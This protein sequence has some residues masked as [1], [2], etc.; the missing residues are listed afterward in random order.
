M[1]STSST[2]SVR[3]NTKIYLVGHMSHQITGGK[4]PSNGQVLRTL[5]YNTRQVGLS[6]REAATLTLNEVTLFW[7]KARIPT[8]LKKNALVKVEKLHGEWHSLQKG[9]HRKS[10]S[11]EEK[12]LAFKSKLEDLFDIAAADALSLLTNPEDIAFL[13]LQREKGR[14]GCMAGVDL[15]TARIEER[16]NAR[17]A[18]EEARR[19]DQHTAVTCKSF[20]LFSPY[21]KFKIWLV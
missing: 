5:F 10:K 19:R 3:D 11:H 2:I 9:S 12:E 4:L 18:R 15:K 1:A 8:Q 17:I 13:K 21:F 6:V 7:E 16:R 14:P 20:L